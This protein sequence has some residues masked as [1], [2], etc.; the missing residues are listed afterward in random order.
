MTVTKK[1]L[2]L[3]GPYVLILKI[4]GGIAIIFLAVFLFYEHEIAEIMALNYSKLASKNILFSLKKDYVLSVGENATLNAAFESNSLKEE[5]LDNYTKIK[6][7]K[8]KNLIRNINILLNKGYRVDEIS[9]ILEHGNSKDVSDFAKRDKVKYLEEFY[10]IDYAKLKYYDRYVAYSYETGE[11][12]ATTV[13][14]VNLNM[15]KADYEDAVLVKDFSYDMLVN[16]HRYLSKDFEP[17]LVNIS[18]DYAVEKGMKAERAALNAFIEMY[19]AAKKDDCNLVITSSYR[20]Y[21]EQEEITETYRELYGDSYVEKYV[22]KPGFSEHQTGLAF[23]VGSQ[24]SNIFVNSKEYTWMQENAY[25]YGFI[26]RFPKK[27]ENITGFRNEA[28][29]YRYV[30]KKMAKKIY[31]D[32]ITLEEYYALYLDK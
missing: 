9:L 29:H 2:R 5:Y 4:I 31:D 1:K 16:K 32:D 30:G 20:S 14:S 23:D 22:A 27:Y 17:D 12:E 3:K 21:Q 13:L 24:T 15:D 26:Y 19:K 18:E 28:W 25:K 11:D 8:Q 7:Q 6:Y 10:T